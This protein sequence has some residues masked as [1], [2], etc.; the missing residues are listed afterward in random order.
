LDAAVERVTEALVDVARPD[1]DRA[2][3]A[4]PVSVNEGPGH[5]GADHRQAREAKGPP[6][7]RPEKQGSQPILEESRAPRPRRLDGA[8]QSHDRGGATDA[9]FHSACLSESA[10]R[11]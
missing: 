2:A 4:G 7:A 10:R 3:R 5:P 1:R 11:I 6:K 9:A 8:P